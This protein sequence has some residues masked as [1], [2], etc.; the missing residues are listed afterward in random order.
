[1]L[2]TMITATNTMSQLQSQL[3]IIGNNLSNSNTH[4]YK[5]KEVKFQ[6]LLYQQFNNDKLD[7]AD[8]QSPVGIRY[9]VGAALAQSQM[10]WKQ[11]SIQSTGR[12]L[13]F[14]F[15][16][17]KQYF[18]V[19]MP[20]GQNG[21]KTAYT[22]QGAFYVSPVENGQ[23]MLVNG[24]GYPVADAQ[25]Q[26]ITLREGVSR[27][28]VNE[29]GVLVAEYPDGTTDQRELAVSVLQKPQFMEHLS[30][31]YIVI[32]ENL[33][34][35][36][37]NAEDVMVDLQGA[38]RGEISLSNQ[39]LEMSNVDVSKEMTDLMTTQRQYQFSARS[40]SIADQMMGLINGI[41]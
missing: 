24:E 23:L 30:A 8:R 5:S 12:D 18:Q 21:E 3:D 32:P 4:G 7:K 39:V 6:E 40:I 26:A 25:G 19:I 34:E 1:M 14:A 27:F 29:S 2:R 17:P 11:G 36:G 41:R 38:A 9:G 37:A 10:N 28:S 33:D 13:D 20:D 15:Q 31:A 16:E 35:L 22:R